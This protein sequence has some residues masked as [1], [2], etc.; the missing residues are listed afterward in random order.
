M[1]R[2]ARAASAVIALTC[3]GPLGHRVGRHHDRAHPAGVEPGRLPGAR[4]H[5]RRAGRP[6][7]GLARAGRHGAARLQPDRAGHDPRHAVRGARRP[8]RL[9]RRVPVHHELRRRSSSGAQNCWGFWFDQHQHA[10][11]RRAGRSAPHPGGG[12]ER[13]R[14]S[15]P[16]GATSSACRPAPPWP[17]SWP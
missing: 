4:L 17:W 15:I 10:G 1:L 3:A 7:P 12:R 13:V 11:P 16:T 8:G 6:R 9:H 2:I 5:R 14:R